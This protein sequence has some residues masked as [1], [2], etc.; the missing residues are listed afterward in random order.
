M[1]DYDSYDMMPSGDDFWS[2]DWDLGS[3]YFYNDPSVE[4]DAPDAYGSV[5]AL[6]NGG[7]GYDL[8]DGYYMDT[9]G[10]VIL[11]NG[12]AYNG[13]G[14]VW[15][16]SGSGITGSYS[17]PFGDSS[18]SSSWARFGSNLLNNLSTPKGLLTGLGGLASLVSALKGQSQLNDLRGQTTPTYSA[19][20]T[21]SLAPSSYSLPTARGPSMT[22]S[23]F[24]AGGSVTRVSPLGFVRF[25]AQQ[26]PDLLAAMLQDEESE[27]PM[28]LAGWFWDTPEEKA[29]KRRAEND[30]SL[31]RYEAKQEAEAAEAARRAG[32]RMGA[33]PVGSNADPSVGGAVDAIRRRHEI[34]QG[35]KRGGHLR[36][37]TNG[38]A[39]KVP[40]MLSDGEYVFDADV[41]SAL[42]DGNNAAGAR[43]LD[44][45]RENIRE[46]KRSAPA[47][48]IPPKA[49][50]PEQYLKKGVK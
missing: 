25:L 14:D 20:H 48:K 6:P 5:T 22:P 21:A 19:A 23:R 37:D 3:D 8:G 11:P 24:A 4:I 50:A 38:Q 28:Q 32:P 30:A 15:S 43:V 33:K 35:L 41:V 12:E 27:A 9:N 26:R 7:W 45:M 18:S 47:S 40:A 10:N 46:H 44:S 31:R 17:D 29:A 36:G 16:G 13:S 39:D 49:K 42:G 1:D 34:L 2:G